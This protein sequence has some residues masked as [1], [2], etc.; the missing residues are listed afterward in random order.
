MA[1]GDRQPDWEELRR[2]AA[3]TTRTK[4]APPAGSDRRRAPDQLSPAERRRIDAIA[5]ERTR[6]TEG[7]A[8]SPQDRLADA[9]S[10][11][12]DGA[13]KTADHAKQ[14][15]DAA[16]WDAP[17]ETQFERFGKDVADNAEAALEGLFGDPTQ[18]ARDRYRAGTRQPTQPANQGVARER[19]QEPAGE[20]SA[21]PAPTPALGTKHE[22]N[23]LPADV[24]RAFFSNPDEA[25][26]LAQFLQRAQEDHGGVPQFSDA[27]W[28]NLQA[29]YGG[30]GE[31]GEGGEDGGRTDPATALRMYALLGGENQRTLKGMLGRD[32]AWAEI[33]A[34]NILGAS[35]A[36]G[37]IEAARSG[38]DRLA[39]AVVP[40]SVARARPDLF[41]DERGQPVTA[42]ALMARLGQG[43]P[44]A[45]AYGG[46]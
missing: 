21:T 15:W 16:D 20:N 35:G 28:K 29:R 13:R 25:G 41:T 1:T 2:R 44:G 7:A 30:D 26:E 10:A 42:R 18:Q 17:L 24:A 8:S 40:E 37:I 12:M 5:S 43:L 22:P 4:P 23:G 9:V 3:A 45:E 33:Y 19:P 32:P 46:R 36:H 39:S 11:S 31:R 34:A 27:T 6:K 38:D 14:V